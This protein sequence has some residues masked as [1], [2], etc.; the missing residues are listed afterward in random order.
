MNETKVSTERTRCIEQN[1]HRNLA[2][3]FSLR[4]MTVFSSPRK[5]GAYATKST[6]AGH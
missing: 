6:S 4:V 3:M 2:K 5:L 1:E